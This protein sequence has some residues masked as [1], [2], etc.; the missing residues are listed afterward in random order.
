MAS[1]AAELSAVIG[2]IYDAAID[3]ALWQ[4]ALGRVCAFVGGSSAVL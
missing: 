3:P 2:D 1:E 4:Q